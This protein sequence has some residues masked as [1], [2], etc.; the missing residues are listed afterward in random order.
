MSKG[1]YM[2]TALYHHLGI[3]LAAETDGN[4]RYGDGAYVAAFGCGA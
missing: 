4:Q 3:A 1:T 2:D